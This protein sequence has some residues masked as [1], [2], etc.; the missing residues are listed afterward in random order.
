[1][2]VYVA[3]ERETMEPGNVHWITWDSGRGAGAGRGSRSER[4]ETRARG[5]ASRDDGVVGSRLQRLP[6]AGEYPMT[7]KKEALKQEP[8]EE[9]M[10][11]LFRAWKRE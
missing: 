6:V 5:G 8:S 3:G 1:M 11:R 7:I 2:C 4:A 10:E 9:Q